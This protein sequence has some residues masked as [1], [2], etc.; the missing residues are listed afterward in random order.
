MG[1]YTGNALQG[2]PVTATVNNP[3]G[4]LTFVLQ[5]NGPATDLAPGWSNISCTTP[6]ATPTSASS[7]VDPPL[8][9]PDSCPSGL[10]ECPHHFW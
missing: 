8:P 2:L 4:C 5:D 1:N 6:C 10:F 9:N 3:T 7:I